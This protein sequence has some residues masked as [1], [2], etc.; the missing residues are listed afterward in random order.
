[1]DFEMELATGSMYRSLWARNNDYPGMFRGIVV[2][3]DDAEFLR[4]RCKVYVPGVY[5]RSFRDN[6]GEQLPWAEPCQPLFCGGGG[7]NHDNGMFQCP[8]V[9]STVFV[10]FDN[11]DITK[12]V[13]FGQ[14][15]DKAGFFYNTKCK[16]FWE[17]M[18]IEM[19]K[20]T[21]TITASAENIV[22]FAS[23]DL[24]G[25][26]NTITLTAN[27]TLIDSRSIDMKSDKVTITAPDV[28]VNG[29][30]VVTGDVNLMSSLKTGGDAEIQ[31]KSFLGHTHDDA[32]GTTTPPN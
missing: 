6:N 25:F 26:A 23:E 16:M 19:D 14:T 3:N 27:E 28:V 4:G 29:P 18:Y 9:G 17:G 12:P 20:T 13:M 22:A 1:M 21:H 10:F 8:D 5:P 32:S 11:R 7:D 30:L 31:G 24:Q 2:N 15:T